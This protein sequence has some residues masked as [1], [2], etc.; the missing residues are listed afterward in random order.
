MKK[1]LK[2]TYKALG[3][4][5]ALI[6]IVIAGTTSVILMRMAANSLKEA[7]Q[8]ERIDKMT[9]YAVE[10]GNIVESVIKDPEATL[11]SFSPDTEFCY[12]VSLTDDGSYKFLQSGGSFKSWNSDNLIKGG[13]IHRPLIPRGLAQFTNSVPP[14]AKVLDPPV[15]NPRPEDYKDST[16]QF[17]RFACIKKAPLGNF[18]YVRIIIAHAPSSGDITND[19]ELKDY[20]YTRTINL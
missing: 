1:I 11:P 6:A 20:F 9:Q 7:I 19:K 18:L 13:K 4:V 5:E 8:N 12:V 3:F 14:E 2:K 15:E 17:Y 10:G 16:S